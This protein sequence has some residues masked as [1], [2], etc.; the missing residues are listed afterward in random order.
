MLEILEKPA[1]GDQ[2][3]DS[4][5]VLGL[6]AVAGSNRVVDLKAVQTLLPVAM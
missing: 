6:E 4:D 1:S 3:H 2:M 5:L